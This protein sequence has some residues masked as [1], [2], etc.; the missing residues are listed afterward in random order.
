MGKISLEV[1][2]LLELALLLHDASRTCA[3][4]AAENPSFTESV[5]TGKKKWKGRGCQ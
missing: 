4:R 1:S 5:N 3:A 2:S